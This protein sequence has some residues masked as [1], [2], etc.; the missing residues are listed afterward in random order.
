MSVQV[1]RCGHCHSHDIAAAAGH[2]H[3]LT[4]NGYTDAAGAGVPQ[5]SSDYDAHPAA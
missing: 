1:N 2:Y 4:C 5:P 3:C